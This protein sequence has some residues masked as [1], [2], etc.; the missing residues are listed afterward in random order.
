MKNMNF[1]LQKRIIGKSLK[2]KGISKDVFD[3]NA[4]I[5]R[6]LSLTENKRIINNKAKVLSDNKFNTD[7]GRF[8]SMQLYEKA[9]E[10]HDKRSFRSKQ[11]DN[12]TRAV[13]TFTPMDLTKKE[14][15]KWKKKPNR[16]DIE[17]IDTKGS[18]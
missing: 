15:R 17:G 8:S 11:H 7:Y 16:F 10:I 5:D 12:N 18:F 9:E 14:F 1:K 2:K 13:E 4:R 3:L 6:K